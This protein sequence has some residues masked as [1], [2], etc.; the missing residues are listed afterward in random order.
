[1][2]TPGIPRSAHGNSLSLTL[3]WYIARPSMHSPKARLLVLGRRRLHE[4]QRQADPAGQLAITLDP[5]RLDRHPIPHRPA[6]DVEWPD[7]RLQQRRFPLVGAE[8]GDEPVLPDPGQ[9][10]AVD[11]EADAA[12]HLLLLDATPAGQGVTDAGG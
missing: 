11:E 9:Y 10:V 12:E 4:L 8:A 1:M 3:I 5:L 2:L 6:S 7:V